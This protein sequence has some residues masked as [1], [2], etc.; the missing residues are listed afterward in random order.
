MARP[1]IPAFFCICILFLSGSS[2]SARGQHYRTELKGRLNAWDQKIMATAEE[3]R[4]KGSALRVP[5]TPVQDPEQPDAGSGQADNDCYKRVLEASNFMLYATD[6]ESELLHRN[7][8]FYKNK[9]QGDGW[10]LDSLVAMELEA[11]DSLYHAETV[12]NKIKKRL[13]LGTQAAMILEA[14]E[15]ENKAISR[16]SRILYSF[17]SMPLEPDIAWLHSED[18]LPPYPPLLPLDPIVDLP[19]NNNL[20]LG[21]SIYA[22]LQIPE[23]KIDQFNAFLEKNQPEI[24]ESILVGKDIPDK[25]QLDKIKK[26]WDSFN[27]QGQT[28]VK[29]E[30]IDLNH[31]SSPAQFIYKVQIAACRTKLTQAFLKKVYRGPEEI[32][33]SFE[34]NWFKY[35]I[36]SYGSYAEAKKLKD[37]CKTRGA[38]IVSY[39]NG[40]RFKI[41]MQ[42]VKSM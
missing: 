27:Q 30:T 3:Y 22:T 18:T 8:L 15:L 17:L 35:T 21:N 19:S 24:M 9:Y 7:I 11:Y 42:M 26:D 37:I 31:M 34:N 5:C 32:M 38:F 16:L 29:T 14:E 23:Q 4:A 25:E 10:I 41:T 28:A 12:R 20:Q 40:K 13:P 39:L 1:G 6:Y 2:G 33:E 36:G